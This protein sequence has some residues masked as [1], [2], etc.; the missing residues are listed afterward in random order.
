MQHGEIKAPEAGSG[1]TTPTELEIEHGLPP[2]WGPGTWGS[3]LFA[4]ALVFSTFQ[5][6]TSIYAVLPS[7]VLR[8]MHVGFLLLVGAGLIANHKSRLPFFRALGWAIGIGGFLVGLYHWVFD[9]DLVNRAGELTQLDLVVGIT[10]L[11]ILFAVS[12]R[13][14]G[15]ALPLICLAFVAYALFG[16]YLPRPLDHRGFS[17]EQVVEQMAF[18]TEGVYATPTNVSATYIY[19]FILF[20]AFLERAGMIQ[21]FNDVA[22][23]I[24]GGR[25]AGRRRSPSCR[26]R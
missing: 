1:T 9:H 7:Q 4:I 12:W 11:V 24:V 15:A 26:P 21:L 22:M 25:A 23:G 19:L 18:G 20:G 8:T 13:L 10:G 2:G 6:A 3:V 14:M 17:L 5:I 16:N